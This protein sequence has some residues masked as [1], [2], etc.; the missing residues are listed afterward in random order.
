MNEFIVII[1]TSSHKKPPLTSV[2]PVNEQDEE[3][4]GLEIRNG[5]VESAQQTPGQSDE[6]VAR[7]VDLSR[8]APPAAREKFRAPLRL[9]ELQVGDL[10]YFHIG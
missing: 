10:S 3:V 2:S 1:K 9:Q 7:V 6:P 5:R 8:S 4:D